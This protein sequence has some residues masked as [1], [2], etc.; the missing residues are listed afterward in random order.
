M[1]QFNIL[2]NSTYG[3]RLPPRPGEY[4]LDRRLGGGEYD[5]DRLREDP[6]GRWRSRSTKMNILL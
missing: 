6:E 3:D 1:R 2:S 5:R 4:D